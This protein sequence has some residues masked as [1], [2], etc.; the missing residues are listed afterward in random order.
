MSDKIIKF[1]FIMFKIK[2]MSTNH[3]EGLNYSFILIINRL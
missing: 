1:S 2:F 3:I